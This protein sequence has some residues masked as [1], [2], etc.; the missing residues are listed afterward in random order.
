[1]SDGENINLIREKFLAELRIEAKANFVPVLKSDTETKLVETLQETKPTKIL[2]IGTA[3]GFSGILML[4]VCPQAVLNTIEFDEYRASE[5]KNNFNITGISDR[6]NIFIGDAREIVPKLTGEY[7]FIFMDGP[8][9]QYIDFLPH[10]LKVLCVGGILFCD[11]VGYMG[12][13]QIADTLPK[14][15]KHIT[16]AKNMSKFVKEITTRNDLSTKIFYDIG[17]GI[18]ITEKLS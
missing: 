11:N 10:L 14:R 16:I 1:M 5:A 2:E 13:T 12:L 17:D 18:S 6:V 9:G 4:N 7:D 15:H 3:I 8:K